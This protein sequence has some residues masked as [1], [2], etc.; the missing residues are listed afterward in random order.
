MCL[1][2]PLLFHS[3]DVLISTTHSFSRLLVCIVFVFLNT[4]SSRGV[5]LLDIFFHM[6]S[7]KLASAFAVESDIVFDL[8]TFD[9]SIAPFIIV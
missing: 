2:H 5:V 6:S 1:L 8:P 9:L 3:V 7:T 4:A